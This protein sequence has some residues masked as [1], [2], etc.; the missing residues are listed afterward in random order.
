MRVCK[1]RPLSQC[2]VPRWAFAITCFES[3]RAEEMKGHLQTFL[4]LCARL[5]EQEKEE[6]KARDQQT[7][8]SRF[9]GKEILQLRPVHAYHGEASDEQ[10]HLIAEG[11]RGSN[12]VY[13]PVAAGLQQRCFSHSGPLNAFYLLTAFGP[14]G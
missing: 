3:F 1:P 6:K 8:K 5:G 2:S 13:K 7:I 14:S 9:P 4:L 10:S 12:S 11:K